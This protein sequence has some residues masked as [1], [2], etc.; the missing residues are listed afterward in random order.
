MNQVY[1]VTPCPWSALDLYLE[2]ARYPEKGAV[3][4]INERQIAC[5]DL[6]NHL[7]TEKPS[8]PRILVICCNV[9]EADP[10][11]N[12]VRLCG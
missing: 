7:L 3:Q 11:Q 12:D 1:S 10:P 9:A 2:I 6:V 8:Y 5:L 4:S